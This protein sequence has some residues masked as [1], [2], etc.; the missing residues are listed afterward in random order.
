LKTIIY[1]LTHVPKDRQKLMAKGVWTGTLKDD[2]DFTTCAGLKDGIIVLVM[3][4]AE[5][6]AAPVQQ[7]TFIE[8]M[9]HEQKALAGALM[10]A[11]L[12]NLGNTCYLN[13]V[14]QSFRYLPE[15]RTALNSERSLNGLVA[16]L[17]DLFN[18]LDR[19]PAG[20][21]PYSFLQ[22]LRRDYPIFGAIGQSGHPLQQDAEEVY[23]A[24]MTSMKNATPSKVHDIFEIEIEEQLH[25]TECTEEPV[26]TKSDTLNKLVCNIRGGSGATVNID[27][28][29]EGLRLGLEDTVEK[30]SSILQRDALWMKKQRMKSLPKY[31]SVQFMRFFWKATP[32][33]ADHTGVKCKILRAVS[34]P[35]VSLTVTF[36]IFF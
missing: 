16:S 12:V 3:G 1:D 4:T 5:V 14:L 22:L 15:L 18:Q 11:G 23:G 8:D 28:M 20:V 29:M 35:R 10:P 17:R 24:L 30:H 2:F 31:L 6:I 27:H 25:C 34:F 36:L 26:V 32:E 33:S 19:S 9:T 7:T 13:S 21:P